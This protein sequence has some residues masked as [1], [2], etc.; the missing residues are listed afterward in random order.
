MSSRLRRN[1]RRLPR[2]GEVWEWDK[3]GPMFVIGP[4]GDKG[5]DGYRVF[6]LIGHGKPMLLYWIDGEKWERLDA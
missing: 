6:F 4:A 2:Y 5:G 1:P 3:N